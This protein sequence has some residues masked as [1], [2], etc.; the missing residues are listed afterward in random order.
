MLCMSVSVSMRFDV[1]NKSYKNNNRLVLNCYACATSLLMDN[2]KTTT[3]WTQFDTTSCNTVT[4][5]R[6]PIVD[7]TGLSV[8][9]SAV[10]ESGLFLEWFAEKEGRAK[11]GVISG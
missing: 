10:S 5:D 9:R 7:T 4:S 2:E 11:G 1:G 6:L 3:S 8:A